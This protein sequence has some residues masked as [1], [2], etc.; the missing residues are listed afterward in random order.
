MTKA[1]QAKPQPRGLVTV[2]VQVRQ[3]DVGLV[4][5]IADALSDPVRER[6]TR[7]ALR[8][9]VKPRETGDLKALLESAPLEGIPLDRPLDYGREVAL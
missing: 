6:A 8:T 2:E 9:Q 5:G 1:K 7:D 4:H 3:K